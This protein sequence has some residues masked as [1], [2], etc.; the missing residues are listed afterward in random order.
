MKKTRFYT[1]IETGSR[2]DVLYGMAYYPGSLIHDP[3]DQVHMAMK[4]QEETENIPRPDELI[5]VVSDEPMAYV[6]GE[7]TEE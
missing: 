5:I 4:I 7:I 1:F 3:V 2:G 6:E